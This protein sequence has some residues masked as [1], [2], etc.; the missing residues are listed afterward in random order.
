MTTKLIDMSLVERINV[1]FITA[2]KA[3][4]TEKKN[5]L[6]LIKSEIKANE[7]RGISPTDENVIKV[8]NKMN[9]SLVESLAM[10]SI[11]AESEIKILNGYLPKLMSEDEIKREVENIISEGASNIGMVMGAFNKKFSGKADNK[12]V[13]KIAGQLL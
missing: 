8:L 1:D 4:E 9:K 7:G 3:G 2:F 6:G 5:F 12:M 13:S 10:G 11:E